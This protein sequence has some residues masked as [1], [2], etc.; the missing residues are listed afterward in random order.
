MTDIG[1]G[2]EITEFLGEFRRRLVWD[3]S[4]MD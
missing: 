1:D 3:Q 4:D 2:C